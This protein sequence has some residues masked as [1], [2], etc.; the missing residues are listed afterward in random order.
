M[1]N[2]LDY[3]NQKNISQPVALF[4]MGTDCTL[5]SKVRG[6]KKTFFVLNNE[7]LLLDT[8]DE[9]VELTI[10]DIKRVLFNKF[11]GN[12]WLAIET[13]KGTYTGCTSYKDYKTDDNK[14]IINFLSNKIVNKEIY[15]KLVNS[16]NPIFYMIFGK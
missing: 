4:L 14:K 6:W 15:N 2:S 9:T 10:N 8:L 7:K 1:K 11:N 12:L 3:K 5:F 13:N 16:K